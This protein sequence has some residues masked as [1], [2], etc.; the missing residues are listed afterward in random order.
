MGGVML[1]SL[2]ALSASFV[3]AQAPA[4]KSHEAELLACAPRAVRGATPDGIAH[5]LSS[6]QPTQALYGPRDVLVIDAGADKG[7]A[8]GQEYFVRRVLWP[9]DPGLE[10]D[11]WKAIRTAGW[12]RLTE[13]TP[14]SA[15]ASVEYA[16]DAFDK[17]DY[18]E[19]FSVPVMPKPIEPEGKP[20]YQA[21][22]HVLFGQDRRMA[23]GTGNFAVID[24]GSDHGL[25][26]GQRVTFYRDLA[27]GDESHTAI[28][29][30]TVAIVLTESATVR[31]DKSLQA[32][33]ATT[34]VAIHR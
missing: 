22:G 26:P 23:M 6:L 15:K 30:G 28:G 13:V 20:D 14:A 32:I 33:Y 12:V 27:T 11:P 1:A 4:D 16:C 5:L 3:R 10:K 9:L 18:L 2:A 29:F 31:V 34:L 24:R 25:K 21:P 19:A 17:G 7:L 8:V